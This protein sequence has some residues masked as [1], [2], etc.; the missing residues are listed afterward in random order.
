[1]YY[2]KMYRDKTYRDKTHRLQNVSATKIIRYK[3]YRWQ[4]VSHTK[5]CRLQILSA[6]KKYRQLYTFWLNFTYKQ[7][8]NLKIVKQNINGSL[9]GLYRKIAMGW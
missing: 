3:M 2:D 8:F 1:M 6:D 4:N 7:N 5:A 9:K